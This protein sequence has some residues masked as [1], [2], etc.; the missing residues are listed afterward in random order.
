MSRI[1][2]NNAL[3]YLL[4]DFSHRQYSF[5][6]KGT[7]DNGF[8]LWMNDAKSGSRVKVE[9]KAAN[10]VCDRLSNLFDRLVF[11]AEIEVQLFTEGESVI[12]RVFMKETPPKIFILRREVLDNGAEF[13]KEPRFVLKGRKNY[14]DD[15]I[16]R[17]Q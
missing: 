5:E 12:V 1:I 10:S 4:N 8:D 9:L 17:L 16:E 14:S 2:E 13:E 6:R 7:S 15:A 3:E 11:N